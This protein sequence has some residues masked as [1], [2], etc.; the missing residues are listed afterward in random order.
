VVRKLSTVGLSYLH[1]IEPSQA[2]GEHPMPDL[3]A[4]FFR[5]LY[6]G[7]LIPAR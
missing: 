6:T 7:T 4:R 1:L 3:S 2:Q 5:P